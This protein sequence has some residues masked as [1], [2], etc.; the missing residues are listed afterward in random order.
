M[1]NSWYFIYYLPQMKFAK[2]MF[3]QVSVCPRG[4]GEGGVCP[5]AC[6]DTPPGQVH[7]LGR[8]TPWQVH[9]LGRYTYLAGTPLVRYPPMDR[10]APTLHSACWDTV[11]KRA[12]CIP[13]ECVLVFFEFRVAQ[14]RIDYSDSL[15]RYLD[16]FLLDI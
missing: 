1:R 6:W 7:P 5:N 15:A 8:Y 4:E 11:N 16:I 13:L 2:V 9:P 12:V 10:Y 3:S 14:F